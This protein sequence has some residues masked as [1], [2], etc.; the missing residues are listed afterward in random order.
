[1]AIHTMNTALQYKIK[2]VQDGPSSAIPAGLAEIQVSAPS[3]KG[4]ASLT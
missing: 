4:R 3:K 1:M 2:K